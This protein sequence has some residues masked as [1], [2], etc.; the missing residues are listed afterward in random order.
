MKR[1]VWSL[2]LL[3]TVPALAQPCTPSWSGRF[4]PQDIDSLNAVTSAVVFDDDGPGP[5]PPALYIIGPTS[6]GGVPLPARMARWD[7]DHWTPVS[8][9]PVAISDA[10]VFDPDGPGPDVPALCF[11]GYQGSITSI[12]AWNGQS[13][14]VLAR[15]SD[16][17]LGGQIN[18]PAALYVL[19]DDGSRP[20]SARL[21][22]G[23]HSSLGLPWTTVDFGGLFRMDPSGWTQLPLIQGYSTAAAAV[24]PDGDGPALGAAYIADYIHSSHDGMETATAT[25]YQIQNG[26]VT[27]LLSRPLGNTLQSLAS[28]DDDGPGPHPASLHISGT[29]SLGA[30]DQPLPRIARWDPP[31]LTEIASAQVNGGPRLDLRLTAFASDPFAGDRPSLYAIGGFDTVGGIEATGIARYDGAL[32]SALG[33]G[34]PLA[35]IGSLLLFDDDGIGSL[36]TRLFAF[37]SFSQAGYQPAHNIAAWDGQYWLAPGPTLDNAVHALVAADLGD[38]PAVYAA[39]AFDRAGE[40]PVSGVAR[41][42]GTHWSPV[43]AP[44]DNQVDALAVYNDNGTPRLVAGGKFTAAGVPLGHVAV[45]RAGVWQPFGGG[46]NGDVSCLLAAGPLLY[47]GGDFTAAAGAPSAQRLAVWNG[48]GWQA[49]GRFSGTV[50][51]LAAFQG[52][53]Y[54]GG[55]FMNVTNPDN[56]NTVAPHIAWFNGVRWICPGFGV[57][58]PVNAMAVHDDGSGPALYVGGLLGAAGTVPV[59]RIARW[60]GSA[61]AAVGGGLAGPAPDEVLALASIDEGPGRSALYAGG[62][63]T[64]GGTTAAMDVA[65]WDGTVWAGLGSGLDGPA[66]AFAAL[67]LD[68]PGPQPRQVYIGGDFLMAGGSPSWFIAPWTLCACYANCDE[69]SVAPV[70]NIS[71]FICFQTRFAAGESYANCDGSTVAPVLNVSDFICFLQRYA[72]GCP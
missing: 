35:W 22:A 65:R 11:V 69:S 31:V 20:N 60:D 43:G 48:S 29:F 1:F 71:D 58:A 42:D 19:D 38:G 49:I 10:V 46:L 51:A 41:W 36:P 27:A 53:L 18:Y 30:S 55:R 56:S 6:A 14:S 23:I 21:Y 57:N 52:S 72:A 12:Y 3:V 26:Q 8:P 62:R 7:A 64:Q 9:G 34:F 28:F 25:L 40:I 33:P 16:F 37:G 70:L 68:G 54:V 59:S 47:A 15:L 67:D 63:F 39:G 50:S 45:L 66:R 13:S 61:W 17:D 32:W 2:P 24:D 44:L 5:H 4:R